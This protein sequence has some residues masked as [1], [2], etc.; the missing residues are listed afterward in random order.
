MITNKLIAL[1]MLADITACAASPASP[2]QEDPTS[3]VKAKASHSA[4]APRVISAPSKAQSKT[5]IG[6]QKTTKPVPPTQFKQ[7]SQSLT[8]RKTSPNTFNSKN[9]NADDTE[10]SPK[11]LKAGRPIEGR[12]ERKK[13]SGL[14]ELIKDEFDGPIHPV[15]TN[16]KNF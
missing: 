14:K 6:S 15:S 1:S 9:G 16:N 11:Q 13:P 8:V 3:L 12:I 5:V 2:I 7:S 4:S 10:T